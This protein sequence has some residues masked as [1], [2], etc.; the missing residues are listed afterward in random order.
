MGQAFFILQGTNTG[1]I[2]NLLIFFFFG[3][4]IKILKTAALSHYQK[5][6]VGTSML[7]TAQDWVAPVL[8][9]SISKCMHN[10]LPKLSTK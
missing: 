5:Y 6:T 9:K 2:A 1:G 7:A 4:S 10:V 3:S 8:C